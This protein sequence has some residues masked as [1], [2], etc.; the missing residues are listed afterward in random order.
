MQC[1][2]R[3]YFYSGFQKNRVGAPENQ[4]IKK[5]WPNKNALLGLFWKNLLRINN[6]LYNTIIVGWLVVLGL[7]AL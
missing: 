6:W 4:K 2:Q 5:V 7:T 1:L 3:F